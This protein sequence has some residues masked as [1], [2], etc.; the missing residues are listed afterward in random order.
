MQNMTPNDIMRGMSKKNLLL[1]QK[2]D[3]LL[4]LSEKKAQAERDY[5]IT[6]AE[7]TLRLKREGHAITLITVLCKGDR[8]V[9]D[10][11]YSYDIADGV[12][13]AAI[14]SIRD[15]RTA[16][17]TYRSILSFQKEELQRSGISPMG[18]R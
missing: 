13:K 17:D 11:K 8:I 15:V 3:E 7:A 6:T 12:H 16:V 2:N 18:D 10:L 1:S 4:V 14:E 9:A 5:N